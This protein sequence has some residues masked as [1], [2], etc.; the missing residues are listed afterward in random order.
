MTTDSPSDFLGRI[1]VRAW[2]LHLDTPGVLATVPMLR[3]VWGAALR[4]TD[5]GAYRALFDVGDGEVAAYLMRPAPAEATPAPAVEF[6]RFGPPEPLLDAATWAAWRRAEGM[7][8]GPDRLPFR[9][10]E[11][12]PL[13]WD[14]SPLA[15]GLRQPGFTL[16]GLPMPGKA[17]GRADSPC[18]LAFPAPLRLIR[19]GRLIEAPTPADLTLAALRRVRSL[20]G[21]DADPLWSSRRDWLDAARSVPHSPWVGRRLDLVRYSGSQRREVELRGVSGH[22]DLPAGPGPLGPLLAASTW[23][24]L[25]KGTVMG[26]GQ[27]IILPLDE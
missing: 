15:P 27:L 12:R 13:A 11:A 4:A 5:E 19:D 14:G 3:G 25:G 7:G 26:L 1:R 16:D 8:L 17:D 22:L 24:H 9:I 23:L 20:A 2:R 21:S 18:R 10:V 6:L